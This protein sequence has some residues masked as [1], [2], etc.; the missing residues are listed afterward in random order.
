MQITKLRLAKGLTQ[1]ELA[2]AVGV[3]QTAVH[4]WESGKNNPRFTHLQKLA[5][6]LDCTVDEIMRPVC[7][8][9]TARKGE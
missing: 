6:A 3:D 2:K 7:I 5:I 8:E 4:M 9:D 1:A